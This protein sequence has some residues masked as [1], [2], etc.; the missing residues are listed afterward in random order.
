MQK[1]K[2]LIRKDDKPLQ[3]IARRIHEI[4]NSDNNLQNKYCNEE[5]IIFKNIHTNG[6][7][8]K[9]CISQFTTMTL[10]GMKFQINNKGNNCCGIKG[11]IIL[12]ENICYNDEHSGQIIIGKEFLEK[13]P[14]YSLPC[15]SVYLGIYQVDVNK[16]SKRSFWPVNKINLKY[17][18]F[19]I[20]NCSTKFAVFPLLH[21]DQQ[22]KPQIQ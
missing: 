6:P 3:Q 22:E 21:I 12:I 20:S 18:I 8:I 15:S 14:L 11:K 1:F 10:S 2:D 13:T 7:I 5:S 19:P 4:E 17:F 9:G 16:L